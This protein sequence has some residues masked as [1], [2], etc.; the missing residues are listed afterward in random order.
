MAVEVPGFTELYELA[1]AAA[2]LRTSKLS[3]LSCSPG[4]MVDVH[5]GLAA[6]LAEESVRFALELHRK[7]FFETAEGAD[8]DELAEDHFGLARQGGAKA[9]GEVTFSRPT[10]AAGNVLIAAGTRVSTPDGLL[11]ATTEEILLTGL[12]LPAAIEALEVGEE[13]IVGVG[14]IT[15]LVDRPSDSTITVTNAER[16]AGGIKAE[17]DADFLNR[18]RGYLATVRRGTVAALAFGATQV[19]GV[20]RAA[21]DE[22]AFPPTVYIADF[23]GGANTALV[24]EVQAELNHWRPAGTQVNVVGATVVNQAI[25]LALTFAAGF[26][27]AAAR[28]QVIEAVIAAVNGLGI[29]ETLFRAQLI[30]AAAGV[31][32]IRNVVV[33][34]PAGDVDPTNSQLIRTARE[35][36]SLA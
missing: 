29:G 13:G 24:V 14:T 12:T 21:V 27:T 30:A 25:T 32:G 23:A 10:T 36:V 26:D 1:K 34:N 16:T 7:T 5:L 9:I 18:I 19:S 6:A 35:L 20:L 15:V 31:A 2:L 28:D 8:L 11:F 3:D 4:Y 22:T 33:V 17:A